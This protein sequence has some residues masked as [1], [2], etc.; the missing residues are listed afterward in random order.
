MTSSRRGPQTGFAIYA[1]VLTLLLGVATVALTYYRAPPQTLGATEREADVFAETRTA[2]IGY[3]VRQGVFQCSEPTNVTACN[4]EFAASRR[5]GEF[6]C[7]DTDNDGAENVNGA[8][9]T[10][11]IGRI[12]WKT[13]G[14]PRPVDRAG[15]TL[16]Y[17]VSANWTRNSVAINNATPGTLSVQAADGSTAAVAL[18][19]ILSPGGSLP[20]QKRPSD[21]AADYLENPAGTPNNTLAAGPFIAGAPSTTF[22]DRLVY[23]R[24][25]EVVPVLETRLGNELK[26]LLLAYKF[27]SKC[28]CYPWADSWEYSGGIGD[29]GVNRGRLASFAAYNR[30]PA[31]GTVEPEEWGTGTIPRFPPWL[32]DNDWHNHL[33]YIASRGETNPTLGGCLTCSSSTYLTIE[34]YSPNISAAAAIVTPGT[35]RNSRI[36]P[37]AGCD[38]VGTAGKSPC[39]PYLPTVTGTSAG[40]VLMN[41]FANFFDDKTNI[42]YQTNNSDYLLNNQNKCAGYNTEH[43]ASPGT[44]GGGSGAANCDKLTRPLSQEYDRNRIFIL[45]RE[46]D[47]P[48]DVVCPA[49][50]PALF[51]ATPCMDPHD[52]DKVDDRCTRLISVL[53]KCSSS[54]RN[55][56]NQ[57]AVVPCRNNRTAAECPPLHASLLSCNK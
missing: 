6:P 46:A 39:R 38:A 36:P 47:L 17:A 40:K 45:P 57:M 41:N 23:L 30:A 1:A 37:A 27:N 52:P 44:Y 54:C 48:A 16:W 31:S 32:D 9:C 13:L 12:P 43:A 19:V 5:L 56:A 14:I 21:A 42:D 53:Q 33:L 20:G 25:S 55:A 2:L 15:E 18:A 22:N 34:G 8:V 28:F 51:N 24:T 3:A 26:A 49:A 35:P 11:L 4:N 10:A 7:P 29:Y 50:G